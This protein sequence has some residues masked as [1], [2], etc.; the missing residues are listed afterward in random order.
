M[1]LANHHTR[2]EPDTGATHAVSI[3][4]LSRVL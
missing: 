3:P 2:L 4:E 1:T